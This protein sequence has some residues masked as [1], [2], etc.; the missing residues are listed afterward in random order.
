MVSTPDFTFDKI[1]L[2]AQGAIKF[3]SKRLNNYLIKSRVNQHKASLQMHNKLWPQ[4][5][6]NKPKE[7]TFCALSFWKT[8]TGGA[9]AGLSVK[10]EEGLVIQTLN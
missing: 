1:L 5:I 10:R 9:M 6:M 2:Q 7:L 8:N 4:S 3:L